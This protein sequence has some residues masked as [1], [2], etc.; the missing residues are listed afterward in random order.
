MNTARRKHCKLSETPDHSPWR[1]VPPPYRSE[2]GRSRERASSRPS[3]AAGRDPAI[4]S[5]ERLD[6]VQQ[7]RIQLF[8]PG[9]ARFRPAGRDPVVMSGKARFRSTD[10]GTGSSARSGSGD[11][12]SIWLVFLR[13]DEGYFCICI[14]RHVSL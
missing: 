6:P 9:T 1:L 14:R 3:R 13:A 5:W 7:A 8:W 10:R 11:R 2:S 4:I 12:K